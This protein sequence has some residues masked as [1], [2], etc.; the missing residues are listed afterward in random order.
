MSITLEAARRYLALV[1]YPSCEPPAST[2][3]TQTIDVMTRRI[4]MSPRAVEIPNQYSLS[5]SE[6]MVNTGDK[7]LPLALT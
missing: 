4:L 2:C 7:K 6:T 5:S 1:R 3:F